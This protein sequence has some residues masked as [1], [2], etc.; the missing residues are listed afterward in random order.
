MTDDCPCCFA[1]TR[2]RLAEEKFR[3]FSC[4]DFSCSLVL[5]D[6]RATRYDVCEQ[7]YRRRR[8]FPSKGISASRNKTLYCVFALCF[9]LHRIR[10]F[11]QSAFSC[12][13]LPFLSLL[14]SFVTV[15]YRDLSV[16]LVSICLIF[17]SSLLPFITV[18]A[19]IYPSHLYLSVFVSLVSFIYRWI[20][21]LTR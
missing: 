3:N 12:S 16:S 14:V 20:I 8:Y 6:R 5:R 4:L 1:A 11:F 2:R 13:I 15:N 21:I 9:L 7:S 19:A 10:W 18:A 17:L